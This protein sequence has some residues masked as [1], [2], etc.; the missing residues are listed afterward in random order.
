MQESIAA[1]RA[2]LKDIK[3]GKIM[4][5]GENGNKYGDSYHADLEMNLR[6]ILEIENEKQ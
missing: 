6:I 2:F 3:S 5:V 4:L 1:I